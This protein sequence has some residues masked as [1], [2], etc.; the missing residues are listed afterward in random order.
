MDATVL[1]PELLRI[2]DVARLLSVTPMTVRN[3]TRRGLLPQPK[4]IGASV[5]WSA[6]EVRTAVGLRPAAPAACP[7][8]ASMA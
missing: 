7:E 5:R 8:A 4:R 3:W 6:E 1:D 2:E